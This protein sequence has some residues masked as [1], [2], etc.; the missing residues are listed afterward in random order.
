M[1]KHVSF[2]LTDTE[3]GGTSLVEH[4]IADIGKQNQQRFLQD[5]YLMF[6]KRN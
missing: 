6:S 1:C 4:V 2:A 3:L 5:I